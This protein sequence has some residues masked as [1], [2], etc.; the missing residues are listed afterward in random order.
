MHPSEQ[1][2]EVHETDISRTPPPLFVVCGAW[3]LILLVG[4]ALVMLLSPT[5]ES[6]EG[7]NSKR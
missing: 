7:C 2:K 5:V 6:G 4:L 1:S 3:L